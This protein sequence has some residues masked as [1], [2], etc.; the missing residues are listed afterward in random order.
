[1]PC[2]C[3]PEGDSSRVRKQNICLSFGNKSTSSRIPT[4]QASFAS[5]YTVQNRRF[6]VLIKQ[7]LWTGNADCGP[8]TADCGMRTADCGLRTADC[9]PRTADRGLRTA[10]CRLPTADCG[11]RTADCR[12]QTADCGLPYKIQGTEWLQTGYK[13]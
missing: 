1:M 13:A 5:I 4:E 7:G 3:F 6:P 2:S 9:G 12:L 11:L 8:R 10:D